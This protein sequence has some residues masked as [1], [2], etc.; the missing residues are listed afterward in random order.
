[1]IIRITQKLAKKIHESDFQEKPLDTCPL[2]DWSANLFTVER[3]QYILL[4]NTLSLYSVLLLGRG[5]VDHSDL[6][7]HFLQSL[8]AIMK[9]DGWEDDFQKQILPEAKG[10]MFAKPLDR[11]VTGSMNELIREAKFFLELDEYSPFEVNKRLND[12]YRTALSW[13]VNTDYGTPQKAMGIL[14]DKDKSQEAQAALAEQIS[15]KTKQK[16]KDAPGPRP[17]KIQFSEAQRKAIAQWIPELAD[18]MKLDQ[19]HGR[20]ISFASAELEKIR[21]QILGIMSDAET[22]MI[23]DSMKHIVDTVTKAIEKSKGLHAIPSSARLYQFKITLIDSNP[24]I[25]RR[26]QVKNCTL[27]K[28]HEHIQ[29]AMG[30]TNSHLH[31]FEIGKVEYGNPMLLEDDYSDTV[32]YDSI[33]V[34]LPDILPENGKPFSFLYV[35]DFG[36]N[37]Q[38]EILFEGCLEAEKGKR[39][40]ICLEGARSCPP[41]DVGGFLGYEVFLE[42]LNDREHEDHEHYMDWC[43]GSFD[44]EAFD[45]KETTRRMRRGFPQWDV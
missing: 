25:W 4:S 35:Y 20:N 28:F 41:E 42:V 34:K 38:H 31:H 24:P 8:S 23:R 32:I 40:P 14:L 26:I 7:N 5:I 44:S 27:D 21:A 18:R 13:A 37:W 15:R 22:P 43:G 19:K 10:V 17:I 33:Q 12:S 30:W 36:D 11:Q 6:I 3:V 9:E 16:E 1:M 45:P 29:T 2:A 39:Y